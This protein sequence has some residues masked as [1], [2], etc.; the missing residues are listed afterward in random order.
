MTKHLSNTRRA[1]K[2]YGAVISR[3]HFVSSFAV[4]IIGV[5]TA[6]EY[7]NRRPS[8]EVKVLV[9]LQDLTEQVVPKS[10]ILKR[11]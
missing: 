1:F 5:V 3:R 10:G 2:I 9:S 8:D 7:A 6:V 4:G 11:S